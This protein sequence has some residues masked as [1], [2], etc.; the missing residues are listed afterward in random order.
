MRLVAEELSEKLKPVGALVELSVQET[1]FKPLVALRS[2]R[3]PPEKPPRSAK[4]IVFVPLSVAAPLS[5][6]LSE[7]V[8][9][10]KTKVP[11]ASERLLPVSDVARAVPS[12]KLKVALFALK[13]VTPVASAP[14][15]L[16][17]SV[18]PVAETAPVFV[19]EPLSV[20][21]PAPDFVNP[22]APW[23]EPAKV[24]VLASATVSV[25]SEATVTTPPVDPPPCKEAI[26]SLLITF[27]PTPAVLANLTVP[28]SVIAL[29]PLRLKVPAPIV[30]RPP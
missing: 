20:R 3:L 29:P 6:R 16:I 13:L 22:P 17:S 4:R 24:L 19:F 12:A 21:V 5:A 28:V 7:V 10:S 8:P 11:F 18:P 2:V 25:C 1:A 26:V 23:S 30:V 15:P 9:S 14:A 27:K